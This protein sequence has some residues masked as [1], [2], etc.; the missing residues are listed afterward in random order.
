MKI[1]NAASARFFS[2][3]V[4]LL[5]Q[6]S[7]IFLLTTKLEIYQFGLWG[8]SM[9]FVFIF[10]TVSQ[11]SYFQNIEKYFPNYTEEKRQY[12]FVKYVKTIFASSPVILLFL[13]II[14][15]FGYFEKFNIKNIN[16]LLIMLAL[17]STIESCLVISD[18]YF[19]ATQKSKIFDTYELYFYKIP[20]LFVFYLLLSYGYSVFYLLFFTIILRFVFLLIIFKNKFINIK[21][22][23]NLSKNNSIIKKNFQNIRYNSFAFGNS[24]LYV[25]FINILFLITSNL[26]LNIDIAH[27]SLMVIILNNLRP[28]MSTIPSLLPPIVS[29]SIQNK[30]DLKFQ[31]KNIGIINQIL[32]SIF[33]L[34]VLAIVQFNDLFSILFLEYFDGIYKLIFL[35]VFAST[36][37]SIYFTKYIEQLFSKEEVNI[38]KFNCLNYIFCILIFYLIYQYF[39]LI[40]FIYIYIIYE[41]LFFLFVNYLSNQ[42]NKLLPKFTEFSF[43]YLLTLAVV[44]SYIFDSFSFYFYLIIPF[45]L[46]LDNKFFNKKLE[47]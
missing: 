47:I 17:L 15:Y 14:K 13:F 3:S 5:I 44:S 45:G 11:M 7:I 34:T 10:S 29:N 8:I 43:T 39:Y 42:K 37:N 1:N 12:F 16:Y 26:L 30:V 36:L 21:T 4:G 20:R 31:L 6:I 18:G 23:L 46:I 32:I 22:F 25:S 24:F 40:N 28:I 35:S 9:S 41:F 2:Y 19:V 27:Y 33:L 38:F